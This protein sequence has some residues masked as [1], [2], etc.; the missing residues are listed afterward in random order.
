MYSPITRQKRCQILGF[1]RI[2]KNPQFG[3]TLCLRL[4]NLDHDPDQLHEDDGAVEE[5]HCL[6]KDEEVID[7]GLV[8]GRAVRV[9]PKLG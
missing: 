5:V 7:V 4:G 3:Q 1:G 8:A 9:L 6:L 2:S